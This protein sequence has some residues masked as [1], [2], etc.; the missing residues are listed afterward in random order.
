MRFPK[1]IEFKSISTKVDAVLPEFL[2]FDVDFPINIWV[3]ELHLLEKLMIIS[4]DANADKVVFLIPN[5]LPL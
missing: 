2:S 4:K 1:G 5:F 3:N